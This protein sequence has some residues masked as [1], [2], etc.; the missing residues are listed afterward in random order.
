MPGL[1]LT[2]PGPRRAPQW[3]RRPQGLVAPRPLPQPAAPGHSVPQ[4]TGLPA[5]TRVAEGRGRGQGDPRGAPER[6]SR[7]GPQGH[8]GRK[9]HCPRVRQSGRR[10]RRSGNWGQAGLE[11][12]RLGEKSGQVQDCGERLASRPSLSRLPAT[13]V[14]GS[15]PTYSGFLHLF[16]PSH[17]RLLRM[18]LHCP[19]QALAHVLRRGAGSGHAAAERGPT[20]RGGAER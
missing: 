15:S 18:R 6:P 3:C 9:S 14:K 13:H 11:G 10:V 1:V 19:P 16:P 20:Q 2:W 7:A 8:R 17:A 4:R 12:A 5:G